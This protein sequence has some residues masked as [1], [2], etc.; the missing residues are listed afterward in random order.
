M[1]GHPEHVLHLPRPSQPRDSGW[2]NTKK[3]SALEVSAQIHEHLHVL[4]GHSKAAGE[5]KF[6]IFPPLCPAT[7][8]RFHD[9]ANHHHHHQDCSALGTTILGLGFPRKGP[10]L[11]PPSVRAPFAPSQG[12]ISQQGSASSSHS[13]R[14]PN[15]S[16]G[17][18]PS[19][20]PIH[21]RVHISQDTSLPEQSLRSGGVCHPR[22]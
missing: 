10:D 13:V 11:P 17:Q 16:K 15:K 21:S 4:F 2:T 20:S 9:W 1:Q 3:L 22:H 12:N 8:C 19:A 14:K 18:S 7:V 5:Q 6:V